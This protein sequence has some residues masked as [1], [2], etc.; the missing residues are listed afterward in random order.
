MSS[1][2]A[3][4]LPPAPPPSERTPTSVIPGS[5]PTEPSPC[6][7]EEPT[8]AFLPIPQPHGALYHYEGKGLPASTVLVTNDRVK[9]CNVIRTFLASGQ[10]RCIARNVTLEEAHQIVRQLPTADGSPPPPPPPPP[11]FDVRLLNIHAIRTLVLVREHRGCLRAGKTVHEGR[12]YYVPAATLKALVR[13]G[14]LVSRHTVEGDVYDVTGAG[15]A[16]YAR[17]PRTVPSVEKDP[18]KVWLP[19]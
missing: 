17:L 15:R 6:S 16:L 13:H 2:H 7:A 5:G 1:T 4:I 18:A 11:A 10:S 8:V 14:L 3:T 12:W 9:G 19:A